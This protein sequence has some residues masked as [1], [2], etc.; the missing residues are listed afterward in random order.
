MLGPLTRLVGTWSP[1]GV[2]AGSLLDLWENW[3]S[4][5]I[6]HP[7]SLPWLVAEWR[8]AGQTGM[9]SCVCIPSGVQGVW[10]WVALWRRW[11]CAG[12]DCGPLGPGVGSRVC[13]SGPW[14]LLCF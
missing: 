2:L 14:D 8:R 12:S 1:E 7:S 13:V 3:E 5:T 6:S 9:K 11:Q 10:G 4:E